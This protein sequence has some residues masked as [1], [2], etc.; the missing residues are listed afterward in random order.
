M[1]NTKEMLDFL[2]E[3]KHPMLDDYLVSAL[4]SSSDDE[5][6]P[7]DDDYDVSDVSK[8]AIKKSEKDLKDFEKKAGKLLD[9]LDP[10]QIAHDFWLTRNGH[11]AGFLDRDYDGKE[12]KL[13]KIAS[14][15]GSVMA[16][17]GDDKKIYMD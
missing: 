10:K 11:G 4:W 14:S 2:N 8:E 9:G 1:I 7:L 6:N 13:D 3:G 17:V 16:Y 5:G 15:F 12:K